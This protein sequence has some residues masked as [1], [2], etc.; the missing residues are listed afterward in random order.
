VNTTV[1]AWTGARE[2]DA[3]NRDAEARRADAEAANAHARGTTFPASFLDA[4]R[5]TS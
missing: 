2:R 3:S 5:S 4:R 1:A